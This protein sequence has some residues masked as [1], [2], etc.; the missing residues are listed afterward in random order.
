MADNVN[1]LLTVL[2]VGTQVQGTCKADVWGELYFKVVA[3]QL[4]PLMVKRRNPLSKA[5]SKKRFEAESN[6]VGQAI[7]VFISF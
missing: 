4:H 5:L 7:Y 6:Y 3:F 1:L 2:M